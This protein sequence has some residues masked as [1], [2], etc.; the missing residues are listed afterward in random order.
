MI[1]E[2][3][4]LRD[5]QLSERRLRHRH[6]DVAGSMPDDGAREAGEIV[7]R[8]SRYSFGGG[9]RRSGRFGTAGLAGG[10]F[11]RRCRS[12]RQRCSYHRGK[13]GRFEEHRV[14]TNNALDRRHLRQFCNHRVEISSMFNYSDLTTVDNQIF[15][16]L[17]RERLSI[18]QL[19]QL[20]AIE[21][22]KSDV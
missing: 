2:L 8:C 14:P 18:R 7:R 21:V 3:L 4:D 19:G 13:L 11:H 10:S 12:R 6:P 22:L 9:K 17:I 1:L 16:V 20:L 15:R 5:R